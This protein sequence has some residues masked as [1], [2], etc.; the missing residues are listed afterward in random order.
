MASCLTGLPASFLGWRVFLFPI[1]IIFV[2]M[3][4][5]FS[6]LIPEYYD[7]L[8]NLDFYSF[9]L[10]VYDGIAPAEE[11]GSYILIGDRSSNQDQGKNNF[12]FDAQVLVDIVIKDGSRGFEK[13]DTVANKVLEAINSNVQMNIGN[14]FQVV[15][16][17]L[18]S[19]NNL[20]GLNPTELTFR[21]LLR[22]EHKISQL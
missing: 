14:D 19:Q 11:T 7:I 17:R 15:T 22:F 1:F 5:V 13:N 10:P 8:S 3:K 12:N 18:L 21:T 16:T 20:S 2:T 6:S 4:N 9:T